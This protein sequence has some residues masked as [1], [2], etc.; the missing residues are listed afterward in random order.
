MR[1]RDFISLIGGTAA[2]WPLTARAQQATMPVIGFLNGT[3]PDGYAPMVSAFHKGLKEA[4]YVEGQNVKIEYR[5]ANGQYDN[6]AALA[7]DLVRRRVSVIAA[8]STPAN[9]VAKNSTATIPIVFTAGNDPVQLGLVASLS[10]PG[11]N[12]LSQIRSRELVKTPRKVGIDYKS[13]RNELP[14]SGF[15]QL[16]RHGGWTALLLGSSAAPWQNRLSC[17]L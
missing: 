6:L 9:L 13:F 15:S 4:G 8:T 11:G 12:P 1:R 7:D 14:R 5:W 16:R 2:I 3:S 17:S 10:R